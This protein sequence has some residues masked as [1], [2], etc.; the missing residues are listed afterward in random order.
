MNRPATVCPQC[1]GLNC[2][3]HSRH[4]RSDQ[5]R[6]SASSRGY[7]GAWHKVRNVKVSM[8]PL[9]ELCKREGK[10]TPVDEVHH[11]RPVADYPELRLVLENLVSLC[12]SHH[13]LVENGTIGVVAA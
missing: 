12:K 4:K 6:G 5:W 11:I 7:D 9:C 13:R 8:D 2:T 3:V 10:V 1:R